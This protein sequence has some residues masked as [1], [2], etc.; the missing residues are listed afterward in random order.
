MD[1]IKLHV[2]EMKSYWGGLWGF[3]CL[4]QSGAYQEI[5]RPHRI[6]PNIIM[7]ISVLSPAAD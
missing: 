1:V 6:T 2:C 5:L 3:W 4:V 7:L